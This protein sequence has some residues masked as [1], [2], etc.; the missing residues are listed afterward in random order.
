M[1]SNRKSDDRPKATGAPTRTPEAQENRMISL[2]VG[3][4]ERQLIDGTASPT[5]INHFLKLATIREQR[6]QEKLILENE[7]LKART[8]QIGS[9]AKSEAMYKEAI[10]AFRVYSGNGPSEVEDDY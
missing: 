9:Q 10:E 2:A 7:L 8:E 1:A 3:L 4:A 5:T 6:E